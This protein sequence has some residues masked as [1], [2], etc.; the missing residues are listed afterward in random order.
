MTLK[1]NLVLDSFMLLEFES[2]EKKNSRTISSVSIDFRDSLTL[3]TILNSKK[4]Q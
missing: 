3:S 1:E 2:R 4:A